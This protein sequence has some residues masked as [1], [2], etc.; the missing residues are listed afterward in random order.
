MSST[1]PEATK[2]PADPAPD[3]DGALIMLLGPTASGKSEIA[4]A[5][6]DRFDLEIVSVDSGQIYR[7]L[8]V[9]SAKP[10]ADERARVRHHLIDFIEPWE[11]Y[12]AARFAADA[13]RCVTDIRARS[14][15]PLLVGGTMLYARALTEGL[16]PLPA[17]DADL[18][19]RLLARAREQG[20]PAMHAWL[21]ELDARTAARLAPHDAQRI[22]RALEVCLLSGRPMSSLLALPAQGQWHGP[23]LRISVEPDDRG[24]LHERI[25][26]RFGA[27]IDAGLID[28]V[29]A[30]RRDA[31]LNE[32]LPAIRSVGY[33]QVWQWL[34]DGARQPLQTLI[35]RG[36]AATRQL[37]KRQ[38]TWLRSMDDRL[39]IAMES[40]DRLDR[41]A[42]A[43][44]RALGR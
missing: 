11:S 9:G 26:R 43:I 19:Q 8:D 24:L 22:E 3:Q 14:R 5:L 44:E 32:Q 29:R 31:R 41:V 37:A 42:E 28:E 39:R 10:G 33:R 40:A 30:L 6:A 16:H 17:A 15:L 2:D 20:W 25:A 21:A 23:V 38:L 36:V 4:M 18:R 12:S 13:R 7:R 35:D 34:D 1:P 27:M